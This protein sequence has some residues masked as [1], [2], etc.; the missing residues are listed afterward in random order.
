M[1]DQTIRG[2]D[3]R[4]WL[5]AVIALAVALAGIAVLAQPPRVAAVTPSHR[6]GPA[7][8]RTAS[9]GMHLPNADRRGLV[10][11]LASSAS[12]APVL[13]AAPEPPGPVHLRSL[14]GPQ[15]VQL[16]TPASLPLE[17]GRPVGRSD[18]M[19]KVAAPAVMVAAQGGPHPA[20]GLAAAAT[21]VQDPPL[22]SVQVSPSDNAVNVGVAPT[23]VAKV[24]EP[25]DGTSYAFAFTVCPRTT[26]TGASGCGGSSQ[27]VAQSG[28]V[29]SGIRVN[30]PTINLN[31][32]NIG[33]N[34][35][36]LNLDFSALSSID[37]SSLSNLYFEFDFEMPGFPDIPIGTGG[38][39]GTGP[40]TP[41]SP[42]ASSPAIGIT[43]LTQSQ[44]CQVSAAT[45]AAAG[46][47][48]NISAAP[49]SGV[50]TD[51]FP[52]SPTPEAPTMVYP[53]T[54][55]VTELDLS[56]EPEPEPATAG[57]GAGVGFRPPSR[58]QS[59]LDQGPYHPDDP[60]S[61]IAQIAAKS[62]DDILPT[63][64]VG[65][66][67]LQNLVNNLYK[68]TTNPNRVGNGTTMDAIRNQIATCVP[69][70]GRMHTIKGQETL[71]GLNNWL[72]R[73]KD[74]DYYDRLVAQGLADKL[75]L[76]LRGAP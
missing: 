25:V 57:A 68:G 46:A 62:V 36:H 21:V 3:R 49:F 13:R 30:I 42:P 40:D 33:I 61:L 11:R 19:S 29:S 65:S 7:L 14:H 38:A 59:Q 48:A 51:C 55:D 6:P 63:P 70:G 27:L 24:A 60:R 26:H 67:K 72:R 12:V 20:T 53:E 5:T 35:P 64:Q 16:D 39:P 75:S 50:L 58:C 76:V 28:W 69:T 43:S 74:A 52:G 71:N 2:S 45:C 47:T 41:G 66:T 44:I 9:G 22:R 54:S 34:I 1:S 31:I 73:N 17:G 37:F 10:H 56:P 4:R 8:D 15:L 23:L 32:P 18:A